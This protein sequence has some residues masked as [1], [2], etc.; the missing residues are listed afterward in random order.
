M[1]NLPITV[2]IGL[3]FVCLLSVGAVPDDVMVGG[4]I[5]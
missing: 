3:L 2:F 1:L 4:V 5:V